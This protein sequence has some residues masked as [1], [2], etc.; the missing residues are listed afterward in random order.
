MSPFKAFH[1]RK[2]NA[3]ISWDDLMNSVTLRPDILK[4]I[5][6]EI[7]SMKENRKAT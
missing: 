5:G 7:I 1:G 4:E 6:N 2:C 3:P